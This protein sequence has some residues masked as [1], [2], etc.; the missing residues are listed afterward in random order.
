[1]VTG[2]PI[3]VLDWSVASASREAKPYILAPPQVGHWNL[4]GQAFS[5]RFVSPPIQS[6]LAEKESIKA[7]IVV[8]IYC[9]S[10]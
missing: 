2:A 4:G 10:P 8:G 5:A 9:K 6:K 7:V 3:L 1:M